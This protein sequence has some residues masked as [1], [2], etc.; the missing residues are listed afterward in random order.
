[1]VGQ[2]RTHG[3]RIWDAEAAA[4]HPVPTGLRLADGDDGFA[5]MLQDRA[6]VAHAEKNGTV[7]IQD[8]FTGEPRST[9]QGHTGN[10][11][12]GITTMTVDARPYLVTSGGADRT[13]RLWDPDGRAPR[14]RPAGRRRPGRCAHLPPPGDSF[15]SPGGAIGQQ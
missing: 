12:T 3:L 6:L 2:S 14:R 4:W 1:M 9:L 8:L 10:W 7:H 15:V 5:F 13:V 11:I